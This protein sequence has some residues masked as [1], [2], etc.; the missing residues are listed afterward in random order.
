MTGITTETN[1]VQVTVI[2]V[3]QD[4]QFIEVPKG[5]SGAAILDAIGGEGRRVTVH[6]REVTP[7]TTIE[8][9]TTAFVGPRSVKQGL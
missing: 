3:G 4:K 9:D 2:R 6:G 1:T 5:S 7:D 8:S